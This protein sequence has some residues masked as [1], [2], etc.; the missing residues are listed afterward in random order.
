MIRPVW[1]FIQ[2]YQKFLFSGLVTSKIIKRNTHTQN[3]WSSGGRVHSS[4][5]FIRDSFAS[6]TEPYFRSKPKT[7]RVEQD[8]SVTLPCLVDNLGKNKHRPLRLVP[9]RI[10]ILYNCNPTKIT[11]YT[12]MSTGDHSIVWRKGHEVLSAAALLISRDP[13]YKLHKNDFSLELQNIRPN[14]AGDFVCQLSTLGEAM[15]VAHTVEVLGT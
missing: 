8:K 6:A 13:R 15:E 14:D 3:T 9:S 7:F 10:L 12:L 5:S 11:Y 2:L 1:Y 4:P